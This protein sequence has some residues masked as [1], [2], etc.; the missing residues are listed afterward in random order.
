MQ[1]SDP[2]DQILAEQGPAAIFTLSYQG[3]LQIDLMRTRDLRRQNTPPFPIEYCHCLVIDSATKWPQ[4][5]LITSSHLC[6]N[7]ERGVIQV[8]SSFEE[9]I[10]M[11]SQAKQEFYAKNS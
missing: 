10:Q 3:E 8:C 4:Y 1:F 2:F 6:R 11:V 5:A 7:F 9:A